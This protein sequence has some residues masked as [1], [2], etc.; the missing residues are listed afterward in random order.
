MLGIDEF[1]WVVSDCKEE[2]YWYDYCIVG[3]GCDVDCRV[4]KCIG[5]GR[6]DDL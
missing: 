3:V 5:G 1:G 4:V 6:V 2:V